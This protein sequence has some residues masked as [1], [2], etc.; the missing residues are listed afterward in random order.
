MDWNCD[1]NDARKAVVKTNYR[2]NEGATLD[3]ILAMT[4]ADEQC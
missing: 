2:Q 4:N 3:A 1:Q